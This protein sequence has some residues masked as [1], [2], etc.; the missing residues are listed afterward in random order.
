MKKL[1]DDKS[2]WTDEAKEV[3]V[4]ASKKIKEIFKEFPEYC[5]RDISHIIIVDTNMNE[6]REMSI[7]QGHIKR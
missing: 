4:F 6:C 1:F 7:R 3:S 5:V 2:E